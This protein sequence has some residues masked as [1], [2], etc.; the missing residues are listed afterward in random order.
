MNYRFGYEVEE[1]YLIQVMDL[2]EQRIKGEK[3]HARRTKIRKV[4]RRQK[5]EN[6][7]TRE[8][9]EDEGGNKNAKYETTQ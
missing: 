6:Q 3:I 7:L 9:M 2:E 5:Q 8:Y 1:Y 4:V